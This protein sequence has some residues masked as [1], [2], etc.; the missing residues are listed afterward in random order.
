[1]ES[2]EK[3]RRQSVLLVCNTPFQVVMAVHVVRLYYPNAD[4]DLLLSDGIKGG[5]WLAENAQKTNAFRTVIFLH[6]RRTFLTNKSITAKLR[7]A[8]GRGYE[9]FNNRRLSTRVA[10]THYDVLLF[11]NTSIFVKM[12]AV[13]LRRHNPNC[14]ICIF[15]EGMSTYSH[16]Y[17]DGD[18]TTTFYRRFFDH[19]GL[20]AKVDTLYL[21]HPEL[22]CWQPS[23]AN[24]V[25]VPLISAADRPLVELLN[26]IFDYASCRDRYDRHVIFFEESHS[27]E[28][29]AVPDVEIVERIAEKIGKDNIMVK[30]HPR[31]PV[32]RF[33]E[34]GFKTNVD[35]AIPWEII[36]LN[37]AFTDT[38]LVTISSGA[39]IAPFLYMGIQSRCYSLLNCLSERPGLMKTDLGELMLRVYAAHPDIFVAPTSLDEF[40]DALS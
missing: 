31:N 13:R 5:E 15:E 28:G 9:L 24:I 14:R 4:V 36:M 6:N 16:M 27:F 37:T 10:T 17:T 12:L 8:C 29:F 33:A 2:P 21:C 19:E 18:A 11:N 20:L 1:M 34:R 23:R 38:V 26:G 35:T 30:I 25:T 39:V 3:N 40:I 22:L 32:N 7:Y